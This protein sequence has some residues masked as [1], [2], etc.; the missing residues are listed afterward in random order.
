MKC[1]ECEHIAPITFER[2]AFWIYPPT[3][4]AT[5]DLIGKLSEAGS[6][7]RA[8]EG[9]ALCVTVDRPGLTDLL[10]LMDE[11]LKGPEISRSQ[12]L[13]TDGREPGPADIGQ[14]MPLDVFISRFESGWIV[15]SIEKDRFETWFQP[16]VDAKNPDAI[17]PF[18]REGLF[19]MSDAAGNIVPPGRVFGI[20]G[21]SDLLFSLDLVARR[22]AVESAARAKI[23]SKIFINFNPSSIY[24]PAY[25]LRTTAAAI[26]DL[27]MQPADI[28]FE[29]T[30]THRA[31]D[32]DHLKGILS[33]Y[34][35]AGFGVALDDIG[36]GW[37]GLNMLHEYKPD[38]VKIDMDL[39]RD[40]DTDGFK[41]TI[42][43]HLI[44]IAQ[45]LGI[46]TI[47]EGVETESEGAWMTAAGVDYLQGYLYGKPAPLA[48]RASASEQAHIH[49]ATERFTAR[50]ADPSLV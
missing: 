31:R 5:S 29:L 6:D 32:A 43:G 10:S 3:S 1:V 39:V 50:V 37:S 48:A 21:T 40:V 47:G 25:C 28:V 33:F 17:H 46:I 2:T 35:N 34:R 16:I 12:V 9:N 23:D 13:T 20:A 22:S 19:R 4:E 36:S 45:E 26:R 18:A 7:V 44:S 38:Y 30:E 24:D 27:G 8:L 15:E 14:I 41:Q 11:T 49:Q 42:V